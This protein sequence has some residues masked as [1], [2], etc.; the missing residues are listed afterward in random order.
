MH[1]KTGS[2]RHRHNRALD[3]QSG[4]S[5]IHSWVSTAGNLSQVGMLILAIFGYFYT[6]LPVYQKSLLDEEIAKKTI[7]LNQKDQQLASKSAEL[8]ALNDALRQAKNGAEKF[9]AETYKLQRT[10]SSQYSDLQ[11]RLIGEFELLARR[12][13]ALDAIPEN[14]FAKCIT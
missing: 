4:T 10:V 12:L 11:P 8:S 13:C 2:L 9:R 14:T 6:V 3:Q 7:E 5:A 1:I